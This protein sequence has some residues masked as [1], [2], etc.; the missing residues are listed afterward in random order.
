MKKALVAAVIV[1][2]PLGA[3][4]QSLQYP[5]FY[6]GAVGGLNWTLNTSFNTNFAAPAFGVAGSVNTNSY[7]QT[8]WAAGGMIGYD[9]VGPRVELEGMY[10]DN[11]ATVNLTAGGAVSPNFGAD[12][13]QTIQQVGNMAAV[14]GKFFQ[15]YQFQAKIGTGSLKQ[16]REIFLKYLTKDEL[17]KSGEPT[18]FYYFGVPVGIVTV[19]AFKR[20]G[21][22]PTREKWLEAVESLK[23]FQTGVF[24]DTASYSKDNHVGFR[25][26]FAVGLNDAGEETVYTAWG[27]PLASGS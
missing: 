10:R 19:E 18:N 4:A 6:I 26:M 12:F 17:P 13:N 22:N 27:K 16:Y 8:G 7:F 2:A 9:F 23:D 5:G 24:A 3:Q 20:A 25:R 11:Q 15:P 14:K 21:P 1:L